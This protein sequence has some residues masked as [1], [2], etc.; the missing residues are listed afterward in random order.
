MDF[1][2]SLNITFANR[3]TMYA[4]RMRRLSVQSWRK[5][6]HRDASPVPHSGHF[7]TLTTVACIIFTFLPIFVLVLII[8]FVVVVVAV[9][10]VVHT[11]YR[12]LSQH[13][14]FSIFVLVLIISFVVGK[15]SIPSRFHKPNFL[16]G[17]TFDTG[18]VGHKS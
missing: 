3:K 2:S 17:K 14:R 9:V 18:A 5:E 12:Q 8:F 6:K 11:T 7:C 1:S 13:L 15:I 10:V 16:S 4:Q